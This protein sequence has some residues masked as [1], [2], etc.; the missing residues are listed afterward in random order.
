MKKMIQIPPIT[1]AVLLLPALA[2]MSASLH[3]EE[4]IT[5]T[6]EMNG[7]VKTQTIQTQDRYG[8]IE[9]QRVQAMYSEIHYTPSNGGEGYDL[10]GADVTEGSV[11]SAHSDSDELMIP[12]WKL[13]SW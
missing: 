11:K 12:S 2:L 13:F 4:G 8:K 7:Q 1:R 9:E 6:E 3:A 5:V 10:I